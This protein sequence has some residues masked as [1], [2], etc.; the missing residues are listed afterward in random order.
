MTQDTSEIKGKIMSVLEKKGPC[1]PVHIARETGL[2]ILFASAFL[3]ELSAEKKINISDMKVGSSPIYFIPE[4]K[5]MLEKFS[6]FLKSKEKEAFILLKE[7]KFLKDSEQEPSIRVAL[8]YLKDFAVPFK[9]DEGIYWRYFNVSE[10][11]FKKSEKPKETQKQI[12]KE[13]KAKKIK[14]KSEFVKRILNFLKEKNIEIIKEIECKKREFLGTA[15]IKTTIG[16]IEIL[17][18]AKDKK[19]I[20]RNDIELA[21]QKSNSYKKMVFFL[22]TGEAEKKSIEYFEENKNII[23]FLK[24]ES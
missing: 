21:L 1:L 17:V 18:I 7:K 16:E 24:L 19:K 22:T 12:K 23:K 13:P 2:S 3:S 10:T 20:T 8:R 11:E 4:Q 9:E 14:E 6:I 15:K 5:A